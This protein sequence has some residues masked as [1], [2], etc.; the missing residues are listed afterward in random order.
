MTASHATNP[1]TL[2]R[3]IPN[4]SPLES[5]EVLP[6]ACA[7]EVVFLASHLWL[8]PPG[9]HV[10]VDSPVPLP[11]APRHCGG[12]SSFQTPRRPADF[13]ERGRR[14]GTIVRGGG[15]RE[16]NEARARAF[17][18]RR[19]ESMLRIRQACAAGPRGRRDSA[20]SKSR[21]REVP[22]SDC[23]TERSGRQLSDAS[24][25]HE[26]RAL[27]RLTNEARDRIDLN[28]MV[29][30]PHGLVDVSKRN[31]R[32]LDDYLRMELLLTSVGSGAVKQLIAM[33]GKTHQVYSQLRNHTPIPNVKIYY[34]APKRDES[35]Q[36]PQQSPNEIVAG[37]S[38]YNNH[39]PDMLGVFLAYGPVFRRAYHKGPVELCDIYTLICSIL[40][41]DDCHNSCGR[42][43]QI[44]DVLAS[45]AR[46]A[47]RSKLR[48]ASRALVLEVLLSAVLTA[49]FAL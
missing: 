3:G 49:A 2:T 14:P 31:V 16:K 38:G 13:D 12:I 6:G 23:R 17:I 29:V 20:S 45:D 15:R 18:L 11:C 21:G 48:R 24:S 10:R 28:V 27:K 42:I 33:P 5:G 8:P 41:V 32:V 34:T 46:E 1:P 37:M 43:L 22:V 40:R 47:V 9:V 26:S 30:S 44:D 35:K 36:I 19:S 25:G 4:T 39:Y 7:H